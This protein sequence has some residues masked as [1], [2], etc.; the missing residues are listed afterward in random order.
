M[1]DVDCTAPDEHCLEGTTVLVVE[2][3]V[4]FSRILQR[5][6]KLSGVS[7]IEAVDGGQAIRILEQDD[8]DRV[9]VVLTDLK[10]PVVSGWE[11]IAVLR[12]CRPHLPVVAMSATDPPP[13]LLG[14]VPLLNKP[15]LP[16]QLLET[17]GPL[18]R[19]SRRIRE[20][21]G[22]QRADA[23]G[24][25]SEAMYQTFVAEQERCR[26]GDL[27]AALL[28]HRASQRQRP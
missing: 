11:L 16:E 5:F 4:R 14:D 24:V 20:Q 3:E 17:L 7:P 27:R 13:A 1:G 25:R 15:F 18:V 19:Q 8:G 12:E 28:G 26:S 22:Q 10:M 23:A 6:L 2:D 9:D 21:S